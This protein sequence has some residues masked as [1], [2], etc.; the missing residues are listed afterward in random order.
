MNQA[1][2][3]ID[4]AHAVMLPRG[5]VVEANDMG[6]EEFARIKLALDFSLKSPAFKF[7]AQFEQ[8]DIERIVRELY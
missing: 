5:E 4:L 6:S 8:W 3:L 7:R 2:A 1:S